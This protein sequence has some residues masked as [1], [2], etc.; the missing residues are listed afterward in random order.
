L[1]HRGEKPLHQPVGHPEI[2]GLAQQHAKKHERRRHKSAHHAG[3]A[4]K[5]G[6]AI[7]DLPV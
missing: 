6:N 5:A 1:P 7:D 2:D 3:L 4:A